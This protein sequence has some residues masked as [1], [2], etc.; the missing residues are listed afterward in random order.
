MNSATINRDI[1]K[2]EKAKTVASAFSYSAVA[3]WLFLI[4][5]YF[6]VCFFTV[7][8][9]LPIGVSVI[10]NA[11]MLFYLFVIFHEA[12]HENICGSNKNLTLINKI[13]GHSSSV[14]LN[15]P[16][17]GYSKSHL[18]HHAYANS[19]TD[20][21]LELSGNI[22]SALTAPTSQIFRNIILCF[23][24]GFKLCK[25]FIRKDKL[26]FFYLHKKNKSIV[27]FYRVTFFFFFVFSFLGI[28]K[29]LF[30]L[31]L[32]PSFVLQYLVFIIFSWIPHILF[33]EKDGKSTELENPHKTAK[34]NKSFISAIFTGLSKYHLE[35]HLYPNVQFNRLKKMA[36]Y[37]SN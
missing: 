32:L 14:L 31:W 26:I 24:G 25:K 15:I 20:P 9:L 1:R 16:F 36:K 37:E 30:F 12:I 34:N 13:I 8:G 10:L 11:V 3:F 27:Y 5:S 2:V 19:K 6:L 22:K 29:N 21:D 33:L 17:T 18:A 28:F 4:V 35:H 23:P 7:N